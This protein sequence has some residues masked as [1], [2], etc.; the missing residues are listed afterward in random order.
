QNHVHL[1]SGRRFP[2]IAGPLSI[3]QAVTYLLDAPTIVSR[4]A[5]MSWTYV[6]APQDGT[7]WLEYIPPEKER[8]SSDG[9]VWGDPETSICHEFNGYTIELYRHTVGYRPHHDQMASHARTRYHL[10]A[11][12]PAVNAAKPDPALWIVHYHTTDA[13]RMLP[14]SQVPFP[15]QM[16]QIMRER[17]VLEAQGRL[18]KRDF[19]LHDRSAWPALNLPNAATLQR[20]M[21][22][23]QQGYPSQASQA[24][25]AMMR[26]QYP[27]YPAYQQQQPQHLQ[28]PPAKRQRPN[29]SVSG[30]S[31]LL[32]GIHGDTSI[33]DEENTTLGDFFDHLTP[34]DISV[35]R[36]MQ[37]HRWMEEV[38]SSPYASNQIVPADLGLGLM[39]E[40]KG[41]TDGILEPPTVDLALSEQPLQKAKEAQPFTNLSKEQLEEFNKRVAT[42]LEE[43]QAEIE[44]MKAEH[45]REMGE[46]KKTNLLMQSEKKLRYATWQGHEDAVPAY[47]LE[48]PS[49][50]EHM[51]D[52]EK[53]VTLEDVLKEVEDALGVKISARK[54]AEMVEK[55]G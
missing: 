42:H 16:Q 26:N 31:V 21:S 3:D 32:D 12:N 52:S 44:R 14:S 28:P 18:E 9:Y 11:K 29:P 7:L 13:N 53:R 4:L 46:W 10:I 33:E 20:Q 54:E 45:A 48:D 36:Y 39:G 22:M 41:L 47:R 8:F 37:H 34:R 23:Q 24:Q 49:A 30:A 2:L 5:A 43:G 6:Q 51:S 38:F 27:Q 15:P 55:G 1:I 40:L 25:A 19:M 17:Q 50:T 35:S